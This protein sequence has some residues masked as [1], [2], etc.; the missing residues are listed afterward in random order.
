LNALLKLH[1]PEIPI[2]PVVNN[3]HAP[4]HK[5]AKKLN[6]ILKTHLHLSNQYVVENSTALALNFT[7]F[8]ISDNHI[9]LTLDIKDLYVNVPIDVYPGLH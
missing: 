5:I 3:K 6:H 7:N 2:K 8:A 1:K 9:L 4:T